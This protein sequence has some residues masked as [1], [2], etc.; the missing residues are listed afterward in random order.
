MK[1]KIIIFSL[2]SL[3]FLQINYA[4][5]EIEYEINQHP[6]KFNFHNK[7][8]DF[9][10]IN[11][12]LLIVKKGVRIVDVFKQNE[13]PQELQLLNSSNQLLTVRE[14]KDTL[15]HKISYHSNKVHMYY[16]SHNGMLNV[17]QIDSKN[18]LN[19]GS[20]IPILEL[21][22]KK[23]KPKK[24]SHYA[25]PEII[26][27]DD[28]SKVGIVQSYFEDGKVIF[29]VNVFDNQLNK[30]YHKQI[31][32]NNKYVH[33]FYWESSL[34]QNNGNIYLSGV[35]DKGIIKIYGTDSKD[36]FEYSWGE[37]R[38]KTFTA[39]SK[40]KI[41][42]KKLSYLYLVRSKRTEVPKLYF[43]SFDENLK[44]LEE[45]E[46]ELNNNA[47]SVVEEY[48]SGL[49]KIKNL[50]ELSNQN[51]YLLIA[52]YF[53]PPPPTPL[54]GTLI[55]PNYKPDDFETGSIIVI[56]LDNKLEVKLQ[57]VIPKKQANRFPFMDGHCLLVKENATYF[58]FYDRMNFRNAN[59]QVTKLD[60]INGDVLNRILFNSKEIKKLILDPGGCIQINNNTV[61]IGTGHG[62]RTVKIS[63]Q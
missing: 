47:D 24:I 57:K 14:I 31:K 26:F 44:P 1:F 32:T 55:I 43:G 61:L 4:Q 23:T 16:S 15:I 54:L 58:L 33:G 46:I 5:E 18:L 3:F 21:K 45:K 38:K 63:L 7:L 51:G 42:D 8:E 17:Q 49:L 37:D 50:I 48:G 22:S 11:D 25:F 36:N 40:L 29:N 53:S 39:L 62:R 41:I 59:F 28:R 19:I 52:E 56:H 6:T 12:S 10:K 9:V 27:S 2:L 13:F 60:L 30:L 34:L 35:S 20:A